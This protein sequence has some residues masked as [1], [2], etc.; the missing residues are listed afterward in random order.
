[1]TR[2]TLKCPECGENF[3]RT[4]HRQQF[5]TPA[6]SKAYNNRQ[7]ARG[8]SVV[9]LAQAWRAS[10]NTSD[11]AAREAGKLAFAQLCRLIDECNTQDRLAGRVNPLQVFR[12]RTAAGLLD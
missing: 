12:T 1:M 7:L 3:A 11:P 10:R 8:Q 5:C 6:H 2:A 4:H 9:G